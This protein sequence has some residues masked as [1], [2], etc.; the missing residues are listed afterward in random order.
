M[1]SGYVRGMPLFLGKHT[2]KESVRER[3]GDG[4]GDRQNV[5]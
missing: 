5:E 3:D 2:E 1:N 4:G